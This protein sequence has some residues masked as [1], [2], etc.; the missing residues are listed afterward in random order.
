MTELAW[1]WDYGRE[2]WRRRRMKNELEQLRTKIADLEK[3]RNQLKESLQINEE[4]FNK[5]FRASSNLIAITTIKDGRII[6]LNE[7][8]AALG[9][10]KREDLIGTLSKD[11]NLWADAK[12]REMV[13]QKLQEEGRV[14]NLEIGFLAE[15]GEIRKTLFSAD[16]ITF[17][18]EPCLLGVSVDITEREKQADAL[19]KSEEKYRM[20]VENSLQGVAIIQDSRYAFCNSSYAGMTGYTVAE[21]LSMSRD[22]MGEMVHPDDRMEVWRR[23]DDRASGKQAESRYEYRGIKKDGTLFWVE[24][25]ASVVEY[26]GKPATQLVSLDITE[27]KQAESALRQS[28]ERFRL[29]ADTIDEIFWIYDVEK[30]VTTY[31]SPAFDRI[32]GIPSTRVVDIP[33]PY[34]DSIHPDDVGRFISSDAPIQA[35]QLYEFEYRIIRPDGAIRSLWNRGFPVSDQTGKIRQYVGVGMDVTER[36][37]AEEALKESREYLNQII[38]CIG[39]P[40]C[41][42][43]REHKLVLV[44]NAFCSFFGIQPEDLLGKTRADS[45]PEELFKIIWKDEE[46]VFA[47]GKEKLSE[48]S[49]ALWPGSPRITMTKKSLLTDKNGNQQIIGVMR[50]I[51]QYKQ[52]EAQFLQA[53]KME[54]I[55]VL[56]GGVAH[57]FN[58]LLNVINGYSEL[59][60]DDLAEDNPIRKDLEQIR[61]AGKRAADL[62]SQLLAFGRKQILQPEILNINNVIV[63]MSSMLR[64]L[65]GE[66]INFISIAEPNLRLV[67]A[68]PGQIQQ[69]IMNLAVNARDAM[70]QGGKLTIETCNID[71]DEDY[72]QRHTAIKAG[73][74]VMLAITDNGMGMDA[75]TQSHLF[76]PF[77]TT[78]QKGKGTGLG[79]STVYGIVKQSNGSLWVY[80]ELGKGTTFK[81]YFPEVTSAPASRIESDRTEPKESGSETVLVVEDEPSVRALACRVLRDRGYNVLEAADGPEALNIAREYKDVIHLILTDVIMPGISGNILVA[82]VKNI[83]PGIK[84]L[85]VSGYT[86]NAIVHHGILDSNLAFL[87][88]PFTTDG[89]A[90]KV[91]EV[92]NS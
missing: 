51:T 91:R 28:E 73:P 11:H 33:R 40:I 8:S 60:L 88:K 52:L 68:D 72:A 85:Y 74:H 37:Q 14:H 87:Q 20:L 21:L 35:G 6:D 26:N 5:I 77:F 19:R 45:L 71:L 4:R 7:A 22:R 29:I 32:W 84:A 17:D 80:S 44:N 58:N 81:I 24:V 89:L 55:G 65:I 57:D 48:E 39:D 10:F 49:L 46:E 12:Q 38:N 42:K 76:E 78:K 3:E 1:Y 67:N 66:D 86:D 63:Q 92:I 82:R 47:T 83:R 69:I 54:A 15:N 59:V 50:D 43:D 2:A 90:R 64:R 70:P 36:R 9:G 62:T 30:E 16:P 79:L 53:Q 56:A 13:V 34:M 61:D 25:Y 41:V 27:H 18:D 23:H 31:L 75:A